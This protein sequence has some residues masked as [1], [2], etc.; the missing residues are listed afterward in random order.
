[1]VSVLTCIVKTRR[2][3]TCL[4]GFALHLDFKTQTDVELLYSHFCLN[5]VLP[6]DQQPSNASAFA[7]AQC[8]E[9]SQT[10]RFAA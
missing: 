5:N 2:Y 9:S 6:V 7:L 8:M 10:L 1:M 4:G 3:G